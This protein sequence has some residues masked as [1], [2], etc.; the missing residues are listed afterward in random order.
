MKIYTGARSESGVSVL[1]NGRPLDWHLDWHN[2][3]PAGFEWGP[4]DGGADQLALAILADF[5][6]PPFRSLVLTR[7]QK[8]KRDVV[9]N[10]PPEGWELTGER[11]EKW[12]TEQES[13]SIYKSI[14]F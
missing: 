1:V 11:I 12:L 10:F 5:W 3:S 2:H 7:Y 4:G 9:A 14:R 13:G 6:G 8:F